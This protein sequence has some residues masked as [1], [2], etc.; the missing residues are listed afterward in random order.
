MLADL[1]LSVII[2]SHQP[3]IPRLRRV[4]DALSRQT[5]PQAQWE[6]LLIDN[7]SAPP[8][9]PQF[10]AAW[11]PHFRVISESTLGLTP[12]R[13]R[14]IAE[15]RG[16]ILVFVDDDCLLAPNYLET[17]RQTF[18]DHP[19]LGTLGGY[20]TAEYETPPPA[21]MPA[22]IRQYHL[23]NQTPRTGHPLFY[24][25]IQ[26]RMGAWFPIGAGLAIRQDAA[27]AY[28]TQLQNDPIARGFDRSGKSLT[29][30]GD[31]DMT[32]TAINHGYAAGKHRDLQ[33]THIVP[34]FRLELPYM[35]RLLYMSN[36]ST[37]RL[38]IHRGWQQ[39]VP[40]PP[41]GALRK[42]KRWLINHWPR[43]PLAQCRHALKRGRIDA[44][45]SLPP[46]PPS[47]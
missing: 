24:A 26:G 1:K 22:S 6:C 18:A 44:L 14:G 13:L 21:W 36:Y 39:P 28:R 15:A 9:A 20:G 37:T 4:L 3:D 46:S 33:F 32:I 31:L 8:L 16:E 10:T 29:G 41:P 11:H 27:N 43:S 45:A 30:S 38:L 47:T 34:S 17:A 2:C 35:L 23:D 7:A 5:L 42:L 12:A 25:R 19:F 40:T